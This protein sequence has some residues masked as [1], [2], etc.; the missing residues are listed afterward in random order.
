MSSRCRG[1]LV[2][3]LRLHLFALAVVAAC[4]GTKS[5]DAPRTTDPQPAAAIDALKLLIAKGADL[6]LRNGAGLTPLDFA[7]A[8]NRT[9][10]YEVLK[11]AAT[12]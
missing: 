6:T 11:A 5:T 7:V 2:D 1:I 4:S 12:P 10:A 8:A 9:A 3:V